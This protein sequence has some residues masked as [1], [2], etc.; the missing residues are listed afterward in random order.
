MN[1]IGSTVLPLI[2][3]AF[4]VG[5]CDDDGPTD[6]SVGDVVGVYS[7]TEFRIVEGEDETDILAEGGSIILDLAPDG[8]MQAQV[9]APG[10]EEG[11]GDLDVNVFGT[12]ELEGS[13]VT[14]DHD[15]DFFLRDIDFRFEDDDRTLSGSCCMTP[16]IFVT[17]EFIPG[18]D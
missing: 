8:T 14:L 12:W 1:R 5:A 18:Q 11:G 4:A 7:A 13:I 6:P 15:E 16:E 17:L 3:L 9:F 10:A 2:A